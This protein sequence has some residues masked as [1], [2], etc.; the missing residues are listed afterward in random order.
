MESEAAAGAVNVRVNF[1]GSKRLEGGKLGGWTLI[2]T[3]LKRFAPNVRSVEGRS[4]IESTTLVVGRDETLLISNVEAP[5]AREFANALK[6]D[7]S[8]DVQIE[9]PGEGGTGHGQRTRDQMAR[10]LIEAQSVIKQ[11]EDDNGA[12]RTEIARL[13][14]A[15]AH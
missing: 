15:Y 1:W 10:R 7:F 11:L 3:A 8:T 9:N 12:L 5:V 13:T 2:D 14:A 4:R 6:T